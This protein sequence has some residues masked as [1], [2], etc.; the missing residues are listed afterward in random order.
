MFAI[1]SGIFWS[2]T[3]LL[4]IKR[5]FADRA[6]G[7]PMAALCLNISWEFIFSFVYP[8]QGLQRYI[9]MIWFGLDL[10]IVYQYLRFGQRGNLSIWRKKLFYPIFI[11]ILATSFG[12]IL[13]T[14]TEFNNMQGDYTAFGQ[15]LLMSILFIFML[16][17]QEGTDGQS[18]YIA[19]F[20]MLGTLSASM[21]VFLGMPTSGLM[22][23][24][25]IAI[26]IFDLL[27]TVLL[28]W[29]SRTLGINPWRRF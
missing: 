1:A 17:D 25:C 15:N 9:D 29:K 11:A 3:Y 28:Y 12:I 6:C 5:G 22:V 19:L 14:T 23:F 13:F 27:Y 2:L 8:H 10:V 16:L 7:M 26:L 24:Y 18:I 20:K 21:I 4:I